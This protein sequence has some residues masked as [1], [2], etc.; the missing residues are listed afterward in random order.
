MEVPNKLSV[1]LIVKGLTATGP[2]DAAT[3][4]S[5]LSE[6]Q[7]GTKVDLAEI[8]QIPGQSRMFRAKILSDEQRKLVL[9]NAK[10]LK[11]SAFSSVYITRDLTRSQR[12]ELY[13]KRKAR[14][15]Q[16]SSSGPSSAPGSGAI[17]VE[18]GGM[19]GLI[20][21]LHH[22]CPPRETNCLFSSDLFS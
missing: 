1:C 22:P 8:T 14:R 7:F 20:S 13:E 19:Q 18:V 5:E 11:G 6:T 15:S 4:F 9:D 2:S 21:C 10:N 3:T 12:T 17:G 16:S